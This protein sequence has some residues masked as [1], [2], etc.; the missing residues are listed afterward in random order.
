MRL[1]LSDPMKGKQINDAFHL[2]LLK[3]VQEVKYSRQ[4]ILSP[5]VIMDDGEEEFEVEQ[6]LDSR[7]VRGKQK[8]LV[9]WKFYAS[10]EKS[11]RQENI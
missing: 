7:K 2:S 5:P 6:T 9:K 8:Y 11:G 10:Y 3:P 4:E 1:K